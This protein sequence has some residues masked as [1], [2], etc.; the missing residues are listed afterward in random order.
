MEW[1]VSLIPDE[2]QNTALI[3]MSE[4]QK[5]KE[6]PFIGDATREIERKDI[7]RANVLMYVTAF[8]VLLI[9]LILRVC[10]MLLIR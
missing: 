9:G 5:K 2:N 8:L 6:K 10:I 7:F 1:N 4:A 3:V